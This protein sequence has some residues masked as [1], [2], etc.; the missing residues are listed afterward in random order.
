MNTQVV[1]KRTNQKGESQ[2][3]EEVSQIRMYVYV[4]SHI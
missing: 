1:H 4:W 2:A 3:D